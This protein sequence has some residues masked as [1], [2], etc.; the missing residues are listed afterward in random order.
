M[1][2]NILWLVANKIGNDNHLF[3]NIL[4]ITP[5]NKIIIKMANLILKNSHFIYFTLNIQGNL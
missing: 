4:N 2:L 5:I 1:K 3:Y